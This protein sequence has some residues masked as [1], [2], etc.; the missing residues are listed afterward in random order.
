MM[1]YLEAIE[2]ATSLNAHRIYKSKIL[3]EQAKSVQRGEIVELGAYHGAGAIALGFGAKE[4]YGQIVFSIDDYSN[5]QGW[6]GEIYTWEDR[7]AFKRNLQ[8]LDLRVY[9]VIADIMKVARSWKSPLGMVFWDL[10]V[11]GRLM[12]DFLAWK[13]LLIPWGKFLIHDTYSRDLGSAEILDD[14]DNIREF[15]HHSV[16]DSGKYRGLTLLVKD[17]K[18]PPPHGIDEMSVEDRWKLVKD[19]L[20]RTPRIT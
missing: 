4:G 5:K 1:D 14:I 12:K 2:K 20:G 15:S 16:A 7:L 10:G 11:N 8:G 18:L 17:F 3:Y 13:D 6:V 19:F 9:L